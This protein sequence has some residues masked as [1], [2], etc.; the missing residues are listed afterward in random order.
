MSRTVNVAV[1]NI[2]NQSATVT[3]AFTYTGTPAVVTAI[4]PTLGPSAGGTTVTLTG[5]SFAAGATVQ[6]GAN[7][8]TGVTVVSATQITCTTAA[9]SPGP[10]NVSVTNPSSTPG[11]LPNSFTYQGA[12]PTVTS[13]LAPAFGPLAGGTTITNR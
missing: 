11:T 7:A 12:A 2:D 5:T 6:I 8:A 9:D 1:T 3:N 10:V 13:L 4:T